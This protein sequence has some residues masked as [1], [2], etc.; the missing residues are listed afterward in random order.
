MN[1]RWP[2]IVPLVTLLL[3]LTPPAFALI[4]AAFISSDPL[5]RNIAFPL[6]VMALSVACAL[7][8]IECGIRSLILRNRAKRTG[9]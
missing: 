2:W 3:A 7:T 6:V 5:G 9:E 8:L 4:H 1:K